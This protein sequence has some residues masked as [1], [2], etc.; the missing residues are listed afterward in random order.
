MGKGDAGTW[1]LG[2]GA[3]DA[4]GYDSAV[5][6]LRTGVSFGT[7]HNRTGKNCVWIVCR[8]KAYAEKVCEQLSAGDGPREIWI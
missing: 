7:R 5:Q 2:E 1:R 6:S 3:R 8:N 4:C